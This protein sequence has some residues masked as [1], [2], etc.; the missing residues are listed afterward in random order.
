MFYAGINKVKV[1]DN[2]EGFLGLFNRHA[3]MRI[4]SYVK[5]LTASQAL[6][7][8]AYTTGSIAISEL[9]DLSDEAARKQRFLDAVL[10]E[11]AHLVPD[12]WTFHGLAAS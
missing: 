5:S 8:L 12:F 4:Y 11:A 1:F 3:E 7:E 2:R 9:L 6:P 10:A